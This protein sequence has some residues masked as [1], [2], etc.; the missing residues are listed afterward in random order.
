[1]PVFS[2]TFFGFFAAVFALYWLA[3]HRW[4][5]ALL[6]AASAGFYVLFG[7]PYTLLLLAC[8]AGCWAGGLWLGRGRSR[9]RLALCVALA[10]GARCCF[11]NT[12]TSWPAA[13]PR[14]PGCW[15]RRSRPLTSNGC[16]RWG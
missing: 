10:P 8:M 15:A 12:L 16:S 14:C 9:L 2:F 6:F 11:S 5:T 7:L 4:R 13:S 1:M 3:P